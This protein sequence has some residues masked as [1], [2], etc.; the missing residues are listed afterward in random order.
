MAPIAGSA[1]VANAASDAVRVLAKHSRFAFVELAIQW[2]DI[3]RVSRDSSYGKVRLAGIP[4]VRHVIKH[5]AKLTGAQHGPWRAGADSNGAIGSG[6]TCRD[7]QP[8]RNKQQMVPLSATFDY[9][10]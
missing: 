1:H 10:K 7:Q 9:R 2:L 4:R 6:E 3:D 8:P 5:R